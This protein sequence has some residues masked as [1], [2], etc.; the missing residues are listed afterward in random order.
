LQSYFGSGKYN[1]ELAYFDKEFT[2]SYSHSKSSL[3]SCEHDQ[4]DELLS[5]V[6]DLIKS[7]NGRGKELYA[8]KVN[9]SFIDRESYKELDQEEDVDGL[10]VDAYIFVEKLCNVF[11]CLSTPVSVTKLD[12]DGNDLEEDEVGTSKAK[13]V[14]INFSDSSSNYSMKI[15]VSSMQDTPSNTEEAKD[16]FVLFIT[17]TISSKIV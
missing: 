9:S 8:I 1:G 10:S 13:Y 3:G 12:A 14:V 6:Y 4:E 5:F 15:D 17:F 7:N 16:A 11:E 2:K